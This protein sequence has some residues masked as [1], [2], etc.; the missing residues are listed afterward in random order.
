MMMSAHGAGYRRY[1]V[2]VPTRWQGAANAWAVRYYDPR[3]GAETFS[4]G[5]SADGS[6]PPTHYWAGLDVDEEQ[7]RSLL[8]LRDTLPGVIVSPYGIS[9]AA[10]AHLR[11]TGEDI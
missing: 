10:A 5:L 2:I 4:V 9:S 11:P 3:G 6:N 7:E 8:V 1:V